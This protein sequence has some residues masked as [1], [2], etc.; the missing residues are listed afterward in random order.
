[1][2][3]MGRKGY[4]ANIKRFITTSE[5]RGAYSQT[6][7]DSGMVDGQLFGVVHAA[8]PKSLVWYPR[9]EFEAAGYRVPE[10]WDELI[11][12]SDQIVADGGVPWCISLYDDGPGGGPGTDWVEDIMLRTTTGDN[13]DAWT[14]GELKFDSP[15]VR[16]AFNLMQRIW[17]NPDYVLGG[18]KGILT[19]TFADTPMPIFDD[20]PG[21]FLYHHPPA[22]A[23]DLP[24]GVKI[25]TDIAYFY[26]PPI[27]N[28]YGRPVLGTGT[29][30]S[31]S[32]DTPV[33][34]Q[35]IKFMLTPA[36]VESEVKA[37]ELISPMDSVPMEWYP[38][39]VHQGLAE[40]LRMADTFRLDSSELMPD[41]VGVGSFPTALI[42]LL[43]GEELRT[44]LQAIDASWPDP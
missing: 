13:Y 3:E 38:L 8:E 2:V 25:G 32:K 26:L 16:N 35:V 41:A 20:P 40:I 22:V 21:C 39:E 10:T 15:E 12:L 1:M 17:F 19:S 34:R 43:E 37:G 33:G 27:D 4:L 29:F 14:R 24:E 28:A 30:V 44:V 9:S 5:L 23:S 36:S 7:I 11:A 31:L 18:T 42:D 6:W